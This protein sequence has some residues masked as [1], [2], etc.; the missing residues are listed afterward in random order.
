MRG[1]KGGGSPFSP[2]SF[3]S[4]PGESEGSKDGSADLVRGGRASRNLVVDG[5]HRGHAIADRVAVPEDSPVAGAVSHGQHTAGLGG[6][7]ERLRQGVFHGLCDGARHDE[8]IR[9]AGRGHEFRPIRG[10]GVIRVFQG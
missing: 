7:L 1:G 3:L 8:E 2:A 4:L 10:E 9:M 5:D 6:G